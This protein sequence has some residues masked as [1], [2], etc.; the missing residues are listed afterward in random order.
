MLMDDY[1]VGEMLGEGAFSIV[2]ACTLKTGEGDYAVKMVDKVESP[3]EAIRR[4]VELLDSLKHINIVKFIEVF[5]EKCFVC[6]VLDRYPGGDLFNGMHVHWEDRGRIPS[7]K[8]SHVKRQMIHAVSFLHSLDVVHRDVKGD[9]YLLD[10]L[11]LVD[12][13]CHVT[14]TDFGTACRIEPDSR[15]SEL[16]GTRTYWSPEF[17]RKDYGLKVDDWAV[18][19]VICGLLTGAF[20]FNSDGAIMD[21]E[22]PAKIAGRLPQLCNDL[23]MRLLEKDEAKRM[24]SSEAANHPWMLI[25]HIKSK[26]T[27]DGEV[28]MIDFD[29][30]VT[31]IESPSSKQKPTRSQ[32]I[33]RET[34]P[35][36]G[37]HERRLELLD[38]Q[39]E[40]H[41]KTTTIGTRMTL[42]GQVDK[43]LQNRFI[44]AQ[45]REKKMVG[46]EW[47][48][49]TSALEV[50]AHQGLRFDE[51]PTTVFSRGDRVRITKESRTKGKTAVVIQPYWHGLVKVMMEEEDEKGMTK[52][53]RATQL[54]L[55]TENQE[56]VV[57]EKGDR[58]VILKKGLLKGKYAV[59]VDPSSNG[60]V[61][62]RVEDFGSASPSESGSG[63]EDAEEQEMRPRATK[64]R[65]TI[66]QSGKRLSY[67]Q[68]LITMEDEMTNYKPHELALA[69][70]DDAHEDS[71]RPSVGSNPTAVGVGD[72]SVEVIGKMLEDH[73]IDTSVWGMGKA[74][75]LKKFAWEVQQGTSQLMLDAT[76]HRTLVRVV[77]I[78]LLK[79][80]MAFKNG[81]VRYLVEI[82][83][84][85]PDGWKRETPRLVGTKKEP[86][87]NTTKAAARV[88]DLYIPDGKVSLDFDGMEVF[89]EDVESK[90][91]PGVR[92]VYRKE[93]VEAWITTKSP[94]VMKRLGLAGHSS[95]AESAPTWNHTDSTGSRKVF[96][97]YTFEECEALGVSLEPI[98][99][100]DGISCL[101][102]APAIGMS[103]EKLYEA[104]K[105]NGID[106]DTMHEKL[107]AKTIEDLAEETKAGES[108]FVMEPDGRVLRMVDLVLLKLTRA[109][110]NDPGKQLIL[111]QADEADMEAPDNKKILQRLPAHKLLP[112]E[113][114]FVVA[115]K[116]LSAKL[117]IDENCVSLDPD[118]VE[119]FQEAKMSNSYPGLLTY[120]RKHMIS[121]EV[122]VPDTDD[123]TPISPDG[124]SGQ[125][126]FSCDDLMA[127]AD[128]QSPNK[129]PGASL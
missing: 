64:S 30:Q 31:E 120:Y 61:K 87:E 78:V 49:L 126:D 89:E 24:T 96:A 56:E 23:V 7:S 115:N 13:D 101:V 18:G 66:G 109:D 25:E 79:I 6:I 17:F 125:P 106:P 128:S 55:I 29:A 42:A 77:N 107:G 48:P 5:Y 80:C 8:V 93:I 21:P 44:V 116:I 97:W 1:L 81:D 114:E 74:K 76:R 98:D 99:E 118:S 73:D 54:E 110:P 60:T 63:D 95:S 2:Y 121:G 72:M 100:D 88:V 117:K 39:I 45:R 20:P 57:F 102:N 58:V 94:E 105:A 28:G 53:F 37:I 68:E 43:L 10:R 11:D 16:C 26:Q 91:Y 90:S 108:S 3:M 111:L 124:P 9:N 47:W 50:L 127:R 71:K 38:R 41:R 86:F 32:K 59:V 34:G 69:S 46:Y 84:E 113:N 65:P 92:T 119:T 129:P 36:G 27:Q 62:V 14:L 103:V 4:E 67:A 112:T 19:I 15:L 123:C 52:S 104:L 51:V 33:A 122:I 12:P 85:T 70:S 22:R 83:E 82:E 35:D 75:T 40:A